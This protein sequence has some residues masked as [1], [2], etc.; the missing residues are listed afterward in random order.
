VIQP[1]T[2][3]ILL[4]AINEVER[5]RQRVREAASHCDGDP[6]EFVADSNAR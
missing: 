5:I 6:R 4:L 3:E 1:I 2:P